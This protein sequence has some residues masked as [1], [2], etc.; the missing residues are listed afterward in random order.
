[1]LEHVVLSTKKQCSYSFF[2]FSE[3][4]QFLVEEI[5]ANKFFDTILC[6]SD[7]SDPAADAAPASRAKSATKPTAS[8]DRDQPKQLGAF[9]RFAN[10]RI[11]NFNEATSRPF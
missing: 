7:P 4:S 6:K 2:Y 9:W 8:G 11:D 3:L 5:E 1:M 10:R